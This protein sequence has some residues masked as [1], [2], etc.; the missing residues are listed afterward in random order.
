MKSHLAKFF[1]FKKKKKKKIGKFYMNFYLEKE[2][3]LLIPNL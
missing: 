3:F 1:F 2:F